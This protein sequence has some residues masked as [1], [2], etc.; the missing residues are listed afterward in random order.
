MIGV[1]SVTGMFRCDSS[2][3]SMINSVVMVIIMFV[4]FVQ[5]GSL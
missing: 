5:W 3:N 1:G 4:M 2:N